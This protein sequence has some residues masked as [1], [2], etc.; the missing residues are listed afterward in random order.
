MSTAAIASPSSGGNDNALIQALGE[1][2]FKLDTRNYSGSLAAL[3]RYSTEKDEQHSIDDDNYSDASS[4]SDDYRDASSSLTWLGEEKDEPPMPAEFSVDDVFGKLR[5]LVQREQSR[6]HAA[7]VGDG[8]QQQS[9][10]P[11][12]WSTFMPSNVQ[13]A[14]ATWSPPA[15]VIPP[16]HGNQSSGIEPAY[17]A[18]PTL[19]SGDGRFP[20]PGSPGFAIVASTGEQVC[21]ECIRACESVADAVLNGDFSARVRCKRCHNNSVSDANTPLIGRPH[22]HTQKLANRVNRMASLLSFVTREIT[23]VARND[24]ARGFLGSQGKIDGLKGN[25][26]DLMN[27]VNTLT[28]IH[29]EQVRS[30]A[31][32]CNAVANGDLSEKL[33]VEL[34]GEMGDLKTT[35]NGMVDQLGAFSVEVT[36]VTHAVGTEGILGVRANVPGV[37]GVWKQLTDNVNNMAN[38]L[39]V[40]VRGISSVCK[41]V[42]RGDLTQSIEITANGEML[43][44]TTTINQMVSKLDMM[45]DEVSRV[46]VEVG[47][48]GKLGGQARVTGLEGTWAAM[49]GNVNHMANNLTSQVRDISLVTSAV[50][51]GDFTQRVTSNPSGEMLKLK[52]TIN[53]MVDRL[54]HLTDEVTR[55]A[56]E[57]GL[58]GRL[59][60]Q[61]RVG[62]VQGTWKQLG[63]NINKMAYNIT[64]QVRTIS[65]V[66]ASVS[67]GDLSKLV[68]IPCQGEME[69]LK[70]T[71]NEMV[72]R[73]QTFSSEVTRVAKE[74]GTDGELGGQANVPD[75]EGIWRNLTNN[76]NKMAENLTDQVRDIARVTTAVAA[77]DLTRKVEIPLDGEMGELKETINT[78]VDQL[79]T[80]AAEVT[81]VAKQV[82]TDGNLGGSAI[83]PNVGGTWKDLT[84]NV[85]NMAKNLTDQV[86]DIA[87]V[88][89]AVAAGD[90][91]QKVNSELKGEMGELKE[92]INTMVDQLSVFAAEVSRVAKEVGTE[93]KLGGEANVAGVDGTW[94]DLTD[95][96]NKMAKNLTD[97]V[98]DIARVTT[99]V[100]AGDL[101]RKVEIPLDGEMGELK[102]TINTMVDQ[103]GTFAAEVSRVAKEVGTDGELGGSAIVPNVGGTWKGLTD[104]VNEMAKNLTNQV[105]DIAAVTKAVAAGD[106]TQKVNSE[107]KGEM[108]ELKETI[109]TMVDQLG[110]FAAE[111]TRVAKEVG[112]DGNLGGEANVKGVD[113]T[114]KDLT[115]N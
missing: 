54:V 41:A 45:S 46:A 44:L 6:Q 96:V 113:G 69:F 38:N 51:R 72:G 28:M 74:V 84:D 3:N 62:D 27:E 95:N 12:W 70:I 61:A 31:H 55:V 26:L 115:D 25:W 17:L 47:I 19:S 33:T 52:E 15:M 109:N 20:T 104:N 1:C 80:F 18:P 49:S 4:N 77:G 100:A 83:V 43:E 23:E 29:T 71:I 30:I 101:T 2:L 63:D 79:G 102:E 14:P 40:Q 108:G 16:L 103:L 110:T 7:T 105:R 90:L 91:T 22:T 88:T 34:N 78:M 107:L 32:V 98:R 36:R 56:I 106:L 39:T 53:G 21:V 42:S 92:T 76:V 59:G 94:K 89:K 67:E 81:R 111:V 58:E 75:V 85:N 65:E 10:T 114:W 48:H 9:T 37:N 87:T 57:V 50:A 24:G 68:D 60:A 86:R 93:G 13:A 64:R 11:N 66:T 35:I 99:A 5:A 112:T 82:G 8:A 73:F 97:Q